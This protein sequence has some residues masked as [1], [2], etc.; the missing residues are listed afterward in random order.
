[1]KYSEVLDQLP[2][3]RQPGRV[4]GE[5]FE[6]TDGVT[7]IPVEKPR[8]IFVIRE[9][10]ATWVPAVDANRIALIGVLTGLL[11]AVIGSLAVLRQPPW[12]LMTITENR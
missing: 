8:G 12:P 9:G 1:M 7:V 3:D 2:T 10:K 4:Y 11:A 6:T 5:P